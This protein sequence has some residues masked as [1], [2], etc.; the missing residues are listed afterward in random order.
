MSCFSASIHTGSVGIRASRDKLSAR[1]RGRSGS[2]PPQG[3]G[4]LDSQR[5]QGPS[6]C[7]QWRAGGLSLTRPHPCACEVTTPLWTAILSC[8]VGVIPFQAVALSHT[9]P[10]APGERHGG[11]HGADC[12]PGGGPFPSPTGTGVTRAPSHRHPAG[13][14]QAGRGGTGAPGLAAP[15]G[16][17]VTEPCGHASPCPPPGPGPERSSPAAATLPTACATQPRTRALEPFQV[18]DVGFHMRDLST[19]SVGIIL[20]PCKGPED[21]ARPGAHCPSSHRVAGAGPPARG[22]GV[23]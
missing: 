23:S 7:T 12:V 21:G 5:A 13:N 22:L 1:R 11:L 4:G 9:A 17:E 16:A 2:S 19:G 14:E 10:D 6:I 15:Q 3:A 18:L 8:E 20:L